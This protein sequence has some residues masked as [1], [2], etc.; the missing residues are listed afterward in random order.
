MEL[1]YLT[2]FFIGGIILLIIDVMFINVN[3]LV[4]LGLGAMI[5]SGLMSF[6]FEFPTNS[7]LI[8]LIAYT[9]LFSALLVGTLWKPLLKYQNKTADSDTDR[10]SVV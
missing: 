1:D 10:K 9:G 8:N 4:F 6:G 2:M 7:L 5:S 3:V